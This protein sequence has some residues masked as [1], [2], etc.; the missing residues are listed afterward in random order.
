M[1][2]SPVVMFPTWVGVK[3]TA[4]LH[5]FFTANVEPHG[6]ELVTIAKSPLAAML[7]MSSVSAVPGFSTVTSSGLTRRTNECLREGHQGWLKGNG[8]T[9]G[10]G[11]GELDGCGCGQG[12]RGAA[13]GHCG[14][15]LGCSG[16]RRKGQSASAVADSVELRR[17]TTR[18]TGG[19]QGNAIAEAIHGNY[20]DLAVPLL[21]CEMLNE[22]GLA[23]RLKS[24]SAT[25]FTVTGLDSIPLVTTDRV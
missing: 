10:R 18:Q 20:R 2:T 12:A 25:T 14:R 15:S 1:V 7:E 13:N 4:I 9:A 16:G 19:I 8:W 6:F 23:V 21:P 5:F 3:V 24:A 17:D 22:L 11:D